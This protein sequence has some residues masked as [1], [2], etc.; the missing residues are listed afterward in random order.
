MYIL[1][2]TNY[3]PR[4]IIKERVLGE[5][6]GGE[7]WIDDFKRIVFGIQKLYYLK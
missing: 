7:E 5:V 2:Y 6:Y 4:G 3:I 1:Y